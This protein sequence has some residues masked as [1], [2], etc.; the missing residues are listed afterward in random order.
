MGDYP[1]RRMHHNLCLQPFK[2]EGMV[3]WR[4]RE[5]L[6][7]RGWTP[8]RLM[9][10]SGLPNMVVYR[11]ANHR[12]PVKVIKGRTLNALCDA[13]GVGPGDLLEHVPDKPQAKRR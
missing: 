10:V 2:A 1:A 8:Y 13:L 12:G 5:V 6:R 7:A 11:I 3:R 9:R 4:V